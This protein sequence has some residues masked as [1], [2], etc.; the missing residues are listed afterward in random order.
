MEAQPWS[1]PIAPTTEVP[2]ERQKPDFQLVGKDGVPFTVRWQWSPTIPTKRRSG[3]TGWAIVDGN[4]GRVHVCAHNPCIAEYL[5]SKY[6]ILPVP[7]H[8]RV[9]A[10]A[11]S[12]AVETESSAVAECKTTGAGVVPDKAIAALAAHMPPDSASTGAGTSERGLPAQTDNPDVPS[13]PS[14]L[15][16]Q[17]SA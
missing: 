7:R 3:I 14:F 5:P 12:A 11:S 16:T 6:G 9:P 2:L 10:S 15:Q 4:L 1:P 17:P 13:A 8:G